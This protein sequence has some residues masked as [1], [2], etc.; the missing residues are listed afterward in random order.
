LINHVLFQSA[1]ALKQSNIGEYSNIQKT[2]NYGTMAHIACTKHTLCNQ[3]LYFL[4]HEDCC[5]TAAAAETKSKC[6]I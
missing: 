2:D 1:V 6:K 3:L 5:S 4:K